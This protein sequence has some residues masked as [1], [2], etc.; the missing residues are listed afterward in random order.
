MSV[1]QKQPG[2]NPPHPLPRAM[3]LC[4]P[5]KEQAG[6]QQLS[7]CAYHPPHPL[8]RAMLLC[9]PVKEQAGLQLLSEGKGAG[10]SAAVERVRISY[11][12]PP[13]PPPQS[14]ARS[15]CVCACV[16]H[17]LPIPGTNQR[18]APAA[19]SICSKAIG[20][21]GAASHKSFASRAG[22]GRTRLSTASTNQKECAGSR[23]EEKRPNGQARTCLPTASTNQKECAGSRKEEKRPNGLAV[24]ELQRGK[25][26]PAGT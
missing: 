21:E 22:P 24:T 23:K 12:P 18:S 13:P 3:L 9:N 2:I 15:A 4:N 10:W 1:C 20:P 16:W 6:L 19:C 25:L 14:H 17:R 11:Q 26:C 7:G 8:P 5:V